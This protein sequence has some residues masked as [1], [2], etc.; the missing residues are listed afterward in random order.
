VTKTDGE[1]VVKQDDLVL[2]VRT[3]YDPEVLRL[4]RYEGFLE[5]LCSTREFQKD[6]IR[7]ACRF[8]GGG[9]YANTEELAAENYA[10]NELL[11]EHYGSLSNLTAA[12]PFRNRRACTIDLA[13]ATGKSW[14]MYGI[15]QILLAEGVVDRVLLL[16]PSLTIEAALHQ[17]FNL[18]AGSSQL[19][20]LLPE[21]SVYRNPNIV[22]ADE[23]TKAGDICI[24][25]IDATYQHV[26]SSVRDSFAGNGATTLVLSDEA[27]HIYS[28]PVAGTRAIKRWKEFLESDEFGFTRHVGLSGTCYVGNDYIADVIYRYSL[29]EAMEEGRVKE[30]RYVAKDDN[31]GEQERFQKILALHEE[32]RAR[33]PSVKPLSIVVTARVAGAIEVADSFVDFLTK[34]LK[35]SKAEAASRVLVVTSA[36][37]HKNNVARLPY[38]DD[39]TDPTEWIFSVSMLTEGWDVQNVFQIV[40]HEKRAFSSKL[41]IAQVLGR[42]LRVPIGMSRPAVWVFNHSSWS[43]EIEDLV[44]EVLDNER[45]LRSYPTTEGAHGSHHFDVYQLTYDTRIIEQELPLKNGDGQVNLFERGY[46]NFETQPEE[47]KRHTTFRDALDQ[48]SD[49][50]HVTTVSFIYYTVDDVVQKLRNRLKSVDAEGATTY[51]KDYP[52][53]RLR[54]VIDKSLE[55]IEERRGVVSEQNLQHALRALGNTKRKMAKTA[56]IERDPDQLYLVSSTGIRTRSVGLGAFRK[57]AT[58]FYDSES[59]Q[60]SEDVDVRILTDL[61]KP[62][63]VYP[64]Q[65]AWKVDNFHFFKS[66]TN[67]VLTTHG[68]EREFVRRMFEPAIAERLDGWYKA[69]D[70]GFYEIAYSWRRGDH[71]RQGKFNPDLFLRLVDGNQILV[72]ELKDDGDD[73]EEN[74][75]KYR[76]AQDHFELINA[77]QADHQYALKFISP[78]SYDAF[79][80]ALQRGDAMGFRSSLQVALGD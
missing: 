9:Q 53:S 29:R 35:T 46:V 64:R 78:I 10:A 23:T 7:A 49:F 65:A 50:D 66:P 32:N 77:L 41:L 22:N 56:R 76:F 4:D 47:V 20:D 79:F 73:S 6:S 26:R 27:H 62:D 42:G 34:T 18:L 48:R 36:A 52:P 17:K 63:S 14:V 1:S 57:E 61:T 70:T 37:E 72:V 51:A 25:N 43:D 75:A 19:K 71:T 28:P 3:D 33:Y 31:S 2:R 67:V 55:R 38:V 69:P 54:K 59:L 8:L 60:E 21:S 45:R 16:C 5:A 40:P 30:V 11:G 15:A 13:T 44:M 58:V 68:P 74:K 39:P 12:L 24:E 80:D